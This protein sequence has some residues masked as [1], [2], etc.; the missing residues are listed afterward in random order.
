MDALKK[1]ALLALLQ[2]IFEKQQWQKSNTSFARHAM[3]QGIR[4][5]FQLPLFT[6]NPLHIGVYRSFR[7]F[8]QNSPSI[9]NVQFR[10]NKEEG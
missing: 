4:Q 6:D 3:Q 2:R 5:R 8:K 7:E 1:E 10:I 9:T